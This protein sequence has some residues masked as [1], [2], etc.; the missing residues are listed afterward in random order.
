MTSENGGKQDRIATLRIGVMHGLK[1][2][3]A[4]IEDY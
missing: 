4:E 1:L 3:S 2:G